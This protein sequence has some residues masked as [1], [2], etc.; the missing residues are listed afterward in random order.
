MY[1]SIG[2]CS[3]AAVS[4]TSSQAILGI[5]PG[6]GLSSEFLYYWLCGQKAVVKKLGQQGT[7]A[8]LNAGMVRSFELNLPIPQEQDAIVAVL[9]DI[10]AELTAL[11]QRRDKTHLLKQGMMQELLTGRTRLV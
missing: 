10:D 5:R 2:E 3:I 8:N 9:T 11:E 4:T 1:A 6:I 7:Q